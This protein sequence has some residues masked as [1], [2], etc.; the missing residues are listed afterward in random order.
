M[1]VM[2]RWI[3]AVS[4]LFVAG[5]GRVTEK[6]P[7]DTFPKEV[8]QAEQTLTRWLNGLVGKTPDEIRKA[9]GAPT[10]ET[11]WLFE[12]KKEL[13]LKYRVGDSTELALYFGPERRVIKVG[14][15][16]LP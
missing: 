3:L 9:L 7:V 6:E 5:V 14:L 16:L 2:T 8:R 1:N 12:E 13:L 4:V 10:K 11:H 15:H